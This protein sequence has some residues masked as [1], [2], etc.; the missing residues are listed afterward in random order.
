MQRVELPPAC[1]TD[2][3]GVRV[4]VWDKNQGSSR[5]ADAELLKSE[6]ALTRFELQ[7]RQ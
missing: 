3:L 1:W 2:R 5:A 4:G 7:L 6:A